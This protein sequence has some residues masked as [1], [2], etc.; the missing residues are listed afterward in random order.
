MNDETKAIRAGY[1]FDT[2][3]T[4]AVPIY[5]TTAFEF[6]SADRAA[7]LFALREFGNI[8]TR[9]SNPT[10][11]I[12]E[13]RF[14]EVEGG[15][16]AVATSSGMSAIFYALANLAE[17]GDNILVSSKVYGG[18]VTLVTH[19]MKRFGIEARFFD[20][21][22]A[23]QLE[24]LIDEKT[25]AI[26]FESIS[27]PS[28]DVPDVEGIVNIGSAYKI[29]TIVDNTVAT[30]ML[31]KPFEWGIDVSV[32]SLSKYVTGQG[33][34]IGGIIVERN[35]LND[36]IKNNDRYKH[37]NE[38]DVSYH[39]L[40]YADLPLPAFSVRARLS[41]LRDIGAI[42]QPFASWLFIQGLE[43]LSVRIQKHS[44]TALEIA[45]FLKSHPKV[46]SVKYP[47]LEDDENYARAKRYFKGGCSGLLSFDVGS[48]ELAK[49]VMD[50]TKLFNR[51]VNI[52]DSK[53]IVTHSA[54]T[55]HQQLDAAALKACG[56]GEGLIR[57]SVGLEDSADLIA[58]L[59]AALG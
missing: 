15:A 24:G 7:D 55:T 46:K 17:A 11:D 5:Q 4:M 59:K 40:V 35:G 44:Q 30:P 20:P 23:G 54:S 3:A 8:Y 22:D 58:D 27:N 47:A 53:S 43:T 19:T 1:E 10:T 18:T 38:P 42:S 14:A 26:L 36:L 34:A 51:V 49:S 45:K 31:F 12:L 39:G 37:F 48:Y 29:V 9:L 57:L 56:I 21:K 6:G 52:G 13:R 41:L 2:Q 16:A 33:L 28:I 32:H 50:S 25:K